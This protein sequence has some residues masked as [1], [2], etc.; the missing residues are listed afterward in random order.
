[1]A[2]T[3][4]TPMMIPSVV[5]KDRILLRKSAREAMRSA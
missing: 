1:M 4:A 5:R 2:I 3:A